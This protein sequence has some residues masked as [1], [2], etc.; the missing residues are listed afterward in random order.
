M[1]ANGYRTL[2]RRI[3]NG[4]VENNALKIVL[5]NELHCPEL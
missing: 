2:T 1:A 4:H 3:P 5:G